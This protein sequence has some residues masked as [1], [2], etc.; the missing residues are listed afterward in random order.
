MLK[1]FYN[2]RFRLLLLIAISIIPILIFN[3]YLLR[4]AIQDAIDKTQNELLLIVRLASN[5]QKQLLQQTSQLLIALAELPCV[6]DKNNA[7]CN[8]FFSNILGN[9][10]EYANFAV[11]K[12][13]GTL[14]SSAVPLAGNL[15]SADL[16]W[17]KRAVQS[18]NFSVGDYQI[19]RITKKPVLVFGYPVYDDAEK[20]TALLMA[21]TELKWLERLLEQIAL[22]PGS[23]ATLVDQGGAVLARYPDKEKLTGSVLTETSFVKALLSQQKEGFVEEK[24]LDG[25]LRLYAFSPIGDIK[26]NAF[27]Y[28]SVGIPKSVALAKTNS[29]LTINILLLVSCILIIAVGSW[30]F[31]KR[32]ILAQASALVETNKELE[33]KIEEKNLTVKALQK[34]EAKL[35]EAQ[36][37]A[38]MGR[39]ELDLITGHLHWSPSIFEIFEIDSSKFIPTYASFLDKVHP[40]DHELVDQAY[41]QSLTKR[42]PYNIEHRLMMKDGRIKWL[43]ETCHT[44]YDEK[45]QAILSV[46]I[47]QDI[48]ERKRSEESLLELKIAME[49]S[50]DGIA[51]ADMDGYIRFLNE[52]WARMHGYSV[53][54]LIGQNLSIFH[55]TEQM[56]K[57][58]IPFNEKVIKNGSYECEIGHVRKDGTIF[59]TLM[60]STVVRFADQKANG[61]L[62]IARDITERK[63]AEEALRESEERFHSLVSNIPGIVYR[64]LNDSNWTV[65]FM[66][67]DIEPLS[68]YPAEDFINNAVRS[69]ASIIHPD[70]RELVDRAVQKGVNEKAAYTMEYRICHIDGSIRWVHEQGQGVFAPNENLLWLDGVILDITERKRSE[71][72]LV[73]LGTAIEQAKETVLIMNSEGII[74]YANKAVEKL[75]GRTRQE[76]TGS[77][78]PIDERYLDQFRKAHEI[79]HAGNTWTG[80]ITEQKK[81]GS[82]Y[83]LDLTIT[84]V[85]D[86]KGGI[87][88]I[89]AIG[90]DVTRERQLEHQLLQSQKM[91]AI[92]TLAGGIAHD[93][94]NI[95]GGILGFTQIAQEKLPKESPAQYYLGET[96][97]LS[98]RAAD[99]VR[100]ILSFS[101][102]NLMERKP[103][104]IHLIV[105]EALKLL[106]ASLPA[107]IEIRQSINAQAGLVMSDP[108]QIHQVIMNLCT[109]AAHAMEGKSGVLGI[110]LSPVELLSEEMPAYPDLQPG[111]YV[112][113]TISDTGTGIDPSIADR[114][115]DP[116]FTTKE[117]GRGTG[118]GLSIVH[119]I[120]KSHGGTITVT[121]APGKGSTFQV[122][123]PRMR[124]EAVSETEHTQSLPCGT[125]RIL[126]VDDEVSLTELAKMMLEP[127]GYKVTA[128]QSSNEA[129]DL[130]Q[131]A[132]VKFDLVITDLS[133]PHMSGY[134]LARKLIKLQPHIPVILCTGFNEANLKNKASELNIKA[135]LTKPIN[136]KV[137][138]E[139]IRT[140]LNAR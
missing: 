65:L 130:F 42:Q 80:I 88:S 93:F 90:R 66:S 71:A 12:P 16:A 140:V 112:R 122:L 79:V 53:G 113:L 94:N 135:V 43:N 23:I 76:L 138:A 47:V 83:D 99:L 26:N 84:P 63:Q 17:F 30:L 132:P 57:N 128:V 89:V 127:L 54:E 98:D 82:S 74:Q 9:Y 77:I 10:Q 85:H 95:L 39:W 120:V 137:L 14:F 34:S 92:G 6:K 55:T 2:L 134:D 102:K 51:F 52:A 123:L 41:T 117:V 105:K 103:V 100:Q 18:R 104:M 87:A 22:P 119:G 1:T 19:G 110:D 72:E 33:Q 31:S 5:E 24:G 36:Q 136:R 81:D 131:K 108:T 44:D 62:G 37:I 28:L 25:I 46:G 68:G 15:N 101:R 75:T 56:E 121:S 13:D 126:F 58:V 86:D 109:N 32:F 133:M 64:C 69:Y 7:A 139:T 8:S 35:Q 116:F 59:P 40:D 3:I 20:L 67:L 38:G 73:R 115:F 125:E 96:K 45:G 106:R 27:I 107:I 49:Q 111:D 118:M 97:K 50:T 114:I 21:S 4:V 48:T 11:Y 60:N 70:D 124:G 61:L 78:I 129:L 29:M 91:E